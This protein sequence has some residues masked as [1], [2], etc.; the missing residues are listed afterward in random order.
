MSILIDFV[1]KRHSWLLYLPVQ[2]DYHDDGVM[3]MLWRSR[4]NWDAAWWSMGPVIA[5]SMQVASVAVHSDEAVAATVVAYCCATSSGRDIELTPSGGWLVNDATI[6]HLLCALRLVEIDGQ[7]SG[8][9]IHTHFVFTPGQVLAEEDMAW[10]A[11]FS[12]ELLS[13]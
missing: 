3:W 1:R 4:K 6:R 13:K 2:T 12:L 11:W 8:L 9:R 10:A 7:V 5:S